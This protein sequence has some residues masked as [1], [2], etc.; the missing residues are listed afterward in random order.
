MQIQKR[1]FGY[2][3]YMLSTRLKGKHDCPEHIHHFL[4]LLCVFDGEIEVKVNGKTEIARKGDFAVI[5]PFQSHG[6]HASDYCKIWVGV[7]SLAWLTDFFSWD[8]FYT[9]EKNVFTPPSAVFSY[10]TEKIPPDNLIRREISESE[11]LFIKMKAIYY[12]ILEE[13]LSNVKIS[14][15]KL[16]MNAVS[17]T[18]LYVYEHYKENITLKKIATAIGYTPNY[19]SYCL[20]VIPNANFRTILNSARV[21]HAKKLLIST[22]MRIIDIALDSGFS[23]ENV[24]YGIFEKFTGM[25]PRKY[26]ISKKTSSSEPNKSLIP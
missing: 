25:T 1:Y 4:E 3:H 13:Y 12:V 19:I 2:N 17:A 23:S 7:I 11:E 10:V 6:Y 24:F 16:N 18:Y 22:D 15:S 26:R 5:P 9:A 14:T 20:S 21:E 8:N